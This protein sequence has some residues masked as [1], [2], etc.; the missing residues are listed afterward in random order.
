MLN[1]HLTFNQ[2]VTDYCKACYFH[3]QTLRQVRRCVVDDVSATIACSIG[4]LHRDYWNSV[5][6]GM[7]AAKFAKLQ[8][9]QNVLTRV[10]KHWQN[11]HSTL[12]TLASGSAA[13]HLQTGY[14]NL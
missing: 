10:L 12:T 3:I 6:S 4:S 5:F 1:K 7:L 13:C 14:V 11:C 2:H 9:V 8:H